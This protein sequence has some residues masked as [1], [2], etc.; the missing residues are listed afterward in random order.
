MQ[1]L[2]ACTGI[3]DFAAQDY[4]A[5][6][7]IGLVSPH[8]REHLGATAIGIIAM[9]RRLLKT[10]SGLA[11]GHRTERRVQRRGVLR[12]AWRPA[13]AQRC[14]PRLA[15]GA[16]HEAGGGGQLDSVDRLS[17]GACATQAAVVESAGA[18][19]WS[20][21]RGGGEERSFADFVSSQDDAGERVIV[22]VIS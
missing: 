5:Q 4:S 20:G 15:R 8:Q 17:A 14:V 3:K 11:G 13:V 7:G 16:G 2:E 6:E 1:C 12:K 18:D 22:Q 10:V 9:R 21:A 19:S